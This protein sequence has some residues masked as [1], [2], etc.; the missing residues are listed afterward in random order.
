MTLIT[1]LTEELE[2]WVN[3]C[4]VSLGLDFHEWLE[5]LEKE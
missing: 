2:P 1:Y 3:N 5:Q 4:Q